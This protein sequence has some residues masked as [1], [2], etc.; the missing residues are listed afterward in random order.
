MTLEATERWSDR[1]LTLAGVNSTAERAWDV[2]GAT[3]EIEATTASGIPEIN[4]SHPQYSLLKVRDLPVEVAGFNF[5]RVRASYGVPPGGSWSADDNPL[6]TPPDIMWEQGLATEPVDR[7]IDNNPILTSIGVAPDQ[8]PQ[9]EFVTLHLTITRNESAYDV[10]QAMAYAN[11]VNSNAFSI[12]GAGTVQPG[13]VLCKTIRPA[14]SYKQNAP[15]IPI[16]YTFELRGDTAGG[17]N[18][19]FRAK[20]LDQGIR[21]N[22]DDGPVEVFD[23]KGERITSPILLDGTGKSLNTTYKAGSAGAAQT[24]R[25]TPTGALLVSAPAASAYFLYYK[26]KKS[27][28]FS[29]LAL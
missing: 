17:E 9:S 16:A 2:I 22:T 8:L 18:V 28:D 23:A 27:I 29:G 25:A 7:D 26:I 11:R 15:Y 24:A 20:I 10:Q 4:D 3:T 21:V 14:S 12:V 19:G 1:R 6:A 5:Y 13:Q